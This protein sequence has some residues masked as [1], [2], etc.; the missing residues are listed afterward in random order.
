MIERESPAVATNND[1]AQIGFSK[2]KQHSHEGPRGQLIDRYGHTH[3]EHVL[4]NWSPAMLKIMGV[5]RL[6][7]A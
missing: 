2:R 7:D 5:R 4:P 3:S 6:G 1:E